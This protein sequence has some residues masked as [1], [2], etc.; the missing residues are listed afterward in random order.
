ME[1]SDY[2]KA[3]RLLESIGYQIVNEAIGEDEMVVSVFIHYESTTTADER[4][5]EGRRTYYRLHKA[6]GLSEAEEDAQFMG[7]QR[8]GMV[9]KDT[10]KVNF[11][12]TWLDVNKFKQLVEAKYG[13]SG[14]TVT[15][16]HGQTK[17]TQEVDDEPVSTGN[18]DQDGPYG[19]GSASI[20]YF[21]RKMDRTWQIKLSGDL[22]KLKEI[23][24]DELESEF[25]EIAEASIPAKVELKKEGGADSLAFKSHIV[26]DVYEVKVSIKR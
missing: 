8:I 7:G 23:E 26:P 15:E 12:W 5:K 17:I 14:L 24:T 16:Q 22:G 13:L 10:E 6:Y 1:L 2:I 19:A 11:S 4:T 3:K 18:F 9:K 25:V 21:T 20:W